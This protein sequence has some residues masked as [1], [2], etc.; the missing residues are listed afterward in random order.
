MHITSK[1]NFGQNA[2]RIICKI[3]HFRKKNKKERERSCDCL[4]LIL[5]PVLFPQI[6]FCLHCQSHRSKKRERERMNTTTMKEKKDFWLMHKIKCNYS[7]YK[8]SHEMLNVIGKVNFRI[9]PFEHCCHTNKSVFSRYF[10][11]NG[12][13]F[14]CP[15]MSHTF[16]FMLSQVTLLMLKPWKIKISIW[17]SCGYM[18]CRF[19][20]WFIK[21]VWLYM[22]HCDLNLTIVTL[23]L[24]I[25][26][27]VT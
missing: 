6:S 25:S 4:K 13:I 14:L 15:P 20:L 11:Q 24:F 23:Y 9:F 7:D 3:K 2:W 26:P 1:R 18:L 12:R 17:Y 8:Y 16:S 22:L 10:F 19:F 27:N 21:S 5:L